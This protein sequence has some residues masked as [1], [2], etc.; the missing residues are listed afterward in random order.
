MDLPRLTT[1][2]DL[3]AQPTRSRLFGLLVEIKRP[4]GTAELAERLELHP[5]GVRAHL[6]LMEGAGLVVR[7][8]ASQARG[9]PRD[10]WK[11]AAD[12]HPD[13]D[14]PS[15]Y[16][17]LGRWLARAI[18]TDVGGLDE[19][20]R[21]GRRI[22]RELAPRAAVGTPTT[23]TMRTTL[24]ALGFQPRA[25]PLAPGRVTFCLGNCPFRDAVRDNP[26]VICTL[27]R[28]MTLGLLEALDPLAELAAFVPHDPDDAGCV[29]ELTGVQES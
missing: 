25:T 10:A 23:E 7:G 26:E 6:E 3:L 9:R 14:P 19:V 16:A 21:T 18:P 17:D 1:S 5:N 13:G 15:A 27:H 28:G 22:G 4:A 20:E 12:P 8:R 29:I 2:N 11:V 24:A